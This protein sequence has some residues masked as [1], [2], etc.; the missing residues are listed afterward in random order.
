MAT[1]ESEKEKDEDA[2]GLDD[3]ENNNA[4]NSC[5]ICMSKI[6]TI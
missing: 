2:N 3:S 1:E 4:E 6:G 5:R